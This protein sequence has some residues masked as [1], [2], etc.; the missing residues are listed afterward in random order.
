MGPVEIPQLETRRLVMRGLQVDDLD[1]FATILASPDVARYLGAPIGRAEAWRRLGM[2]VGHW[3]LMGFGRWA[4]T[5]RETQRLIGWTG[6]LRIEGFEEP[7]VG[8]VLHREA[9]G[10]G[11]ATEAA[12]AAFPWA[13]RNLRPEALISLIHPDN[14]SS[15]SVAE[16]L[17]ATVWRQADDDHGVTHLVYR[18]DLQRWR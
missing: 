17:G 9:W 2:H 1:G 11:Y 3:A 12:S 14:H 10:R 15:I 18:H 13:V 8:W 6:V 16:R 5:E 7:E 4:I